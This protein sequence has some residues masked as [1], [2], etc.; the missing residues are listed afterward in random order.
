VPEN[1]IETVRLLIVS[2]EPA[3]L[4]PLWSVGEA[5][6]WHIETAGSGWEALE[7]IQSGAVPHLLLLDLPRGN[8]DSL[9]MLRWLR[10]VRPELPIILLSHCADLSREKEAL[11]LGAQDFLIKPFDE[12][13]IEAA[14]HRHLSSHSEERRDFTSENIEQLSEDAFFVAASPA[15]QKVRAQAE[16]LAQA[17]VPVLIVGEAGSGRDTTARLIHKLSLRSGFRFL[18]VNCGALP[19]DLLEK[20]LFGYGGNPARGNDP[21]TPGKLELCERGTIFIDEIEE[22]P[23]NVQEKLLRVVQEKQMARAGNGHCVDIDVRILAASETG[24]HG[25]LAEEK[26]REDLYCR[27]SAFTVHVPALRQRRDELPLLLHHFMHKLARRYGLPAR[28]FSSEVIEAC[29]RHSWPG[30]VTE[31]ESFVKRYLMIGDGEV[32]RGGYSEAFASND[33]LASGAPNHKGP[34]MADYDLGGGKSLKSLIRDVTSE[35]ERNAIA[36]ALER[37]GWNRKAAA[38]LLKVSYRTML[39]KIEQYQM[40]SSDSFPIPFV[41]GNA[42]KGNGNPLK[43]NGKAN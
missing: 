40:N 37:T 35:A 8:A 5:N 20:E 33:P 18:K 25:T 30:N 13:Q 19:G 17:D 4:R 12:S 16:L 27:L 28:E 39:Y 34:S 14:I 41:N 22:M 31:L 29:R 32:R 15:M 26:L 42:G 24:L 43:G 2:R 21:P 3:V 9:H 38:R 23:A 7:R 36:A 11:R 6:S 10:R 1:A